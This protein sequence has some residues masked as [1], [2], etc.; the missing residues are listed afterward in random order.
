MIITMIRGYKQR[1]EKS[2]KIVGTKVY[3]K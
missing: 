1:C 3:E 2:V